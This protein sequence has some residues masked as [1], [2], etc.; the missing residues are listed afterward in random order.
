M[1]YTSRGRRRMGL[2]LLTVVALAALGLGSASARS[3]HRHR[4]GSRHHGTGG[5]SITSE[6]WGT[7]DGHAVTLYTLVQRPSHEGED[8]Q[9]RRGRAVDLGAGPPR[10]RDN[11]ALGFSSLSDYVNDFTQARPTLAAP[12][13]QGT[14]TSARSSAATPTGSPKRRSRSTAQT[15]HARREQRHEHPPRRLPRLEHAGVD[16]DRPRQ[17]SSAV[18][19]LTHSS[20]KATAS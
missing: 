4:T 5:L 2:V 15:Y 14:R 1:Q 6:P 20:R 19:E 16:A 8:H 12:A 7:A 18:L 13:G 11:V 17:A 3:A 9:L 10:A